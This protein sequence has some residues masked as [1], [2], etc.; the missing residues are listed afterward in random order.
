VDNLSDLL[1]KQTVATTSA[2]RA[3][4]LLGGG[5]TLSFEAISLG[6]LIYDRVRIDPSSIEAFDFLHPANESDIHALACWSQHIVDSGPS[7]TYEGHLN[8]LQGY[9]F[10]RMAAHA[11]RQSGAEVIFPDSPTNPGIDFWVNG[12]PIQAKC[13]LSPSLVTEHLSSYPDVP[14]VVVN[15]DLASHFANNDHITIIPGITR[16][17]VRSTTEHSLNTSADMLDLHLVDVVPVISVVRNAYHLWRGNSDWSAMLGNIAADAAGRYVGS[18]VGKVVGAGTVLMLGLGGW[19]AILLPVF[20]ATVGYRGGRVLSNLVKKELFLRVEHNALSKALQWWC[21]GAARVLT[22]M[23]NCAEDIR[24]RFVGVRDR[25][26]ASYRAMIDDWLLRTKREQE[27]RHHHLA[28]FER[29]ASDSSV[30]D[31]GAG[32]PAAC[33]AAMVAASR[34]GILPADLSRERTL[35]ITSLNAYQT[36]LNRRLLRH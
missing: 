6:D 18:G 20:A 33:L 10:E 16:D 30:F 11:L 14:R 12:E 29:G 35:L 23:I 7:A 24:L 32:L 13:G 17:S 28:R 31:D 21:L 26:H 19:P 27:F 3:A 1:R 36:G 22:G 25:G 2:R 5:D 8:Q 15:Q 9:V 4:A 34:A